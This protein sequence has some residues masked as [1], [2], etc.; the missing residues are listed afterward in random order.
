M[1]AAANQTAGARATGRS[2]SEDFG[3][4]PK[5]QGR[6][7]PPRP[8][9]IY[10]YPLSAPVVREQSHIGAAGREQSHP[11]EGWLAIGDKFLEKAIQEK[12]RVLRRETVGPQDRSYGE[13][14]VPSAMLA[15]ILPE[16]PIHRILGNPTVGKSQDNQS[17]RF[18][19]I[20]DHFNKWAPSTVD[21]A[22]TVF[23][24]LSA[25]ASSR[26]TDVWDLSPGQLASF[27][28]ERE[29]QGVDRGKRKFERAPVG[30]PPARSPELK[31]RGNDGSTVAGTV[32]TNLRWLVKRAG[33]PW[34]VDAPILFRIA[35]PRGTG[36][37]PASYTLGIVVRLES[38]LLDKAEYSPFVKGQVAGLLAMTRACLRLQ[39][40]NAVRFDRVLHGCVQGVLHRQKAPSHA[41]QVKRFCLA[42]I[43]HMIEGASWYGTL[44]K[45]LAGVETGQFVMRD[46]NSVDGDPFRATGWAP[47]ALRGD[48]FRKA[49]RAILVR[50]CGLS[51]EEA[52]AFGSSSARHFAPEVAL[53]RG[54]PAHLRV[55]IGQWSQS[56]FQDRDLMPH[57]R[58]AEE[59]R[60]S[61]AVMP[62]RYAPQA[63]LMTAARVLTSQ[64][65][66]AK[67]I[68]EDKGLEAIPITGGWQILSEDKWRYKDGEV[69]P[70]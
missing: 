54:Y 51:W 46:T 67:A 62:D 36:T 41:G 42:P 49:Q 66:V 61:A 45:T 2:L 31:R 9:P 58:K 35:P 28:R 23:L 34:E 70:Q 4:P 6:E 56:S 60:R 22:R 44:R 55:E 20:V 1:E 39:Q 40:A 21:G 38:A 29:A 18:A 27:I 43:M 69:G 26:G 52:A 16:R 17:E 7:G 8:P 14:V 15:R 50:I 33:C 13:R 53:A 63:K 57:E 25:W 3:L 68:L 19:A 12:D 11:S 48:R 24:S 10:P 64:F 59:A 47:G 5:G 37:P 30:S 32:M 65:K